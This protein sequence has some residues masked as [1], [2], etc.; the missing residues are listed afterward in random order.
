MEAR[1]CVWRGGNAAT[2]RQPSPSAGH[3]ARSRRAPSPE[4]CLA[5]WT[6]AAP[7]LRHMTA[8]A[9]HPVAIIHVRGYDAGDSRLASDSV[10]D[11]VSTQCQA[12]SLNA[13]HNTSMCTTCQ[14]SPWSMPKHHG[15]CSESRIVQCQ[16]RNMLHL[17]LRSCVGRQNKC[18]RPL[19]LQ[20][21]L[22]A[23]PHAASVV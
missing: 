11:S 22:A 4:C 5:R 17:E 16:S 3:A 1:M 2:H 13:V 10:L 23:A 18:T 14:K 21:A 19:P 8:T 9:E 15:A 20:P 6:A 7:H 12:A